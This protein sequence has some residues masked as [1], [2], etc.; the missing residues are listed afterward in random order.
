[1]KKDKYQKRRNRQR[2]FNQYDPE[3]HPAPKPP[4]AKVDEARP[5]PTH[6]PGELEDQA[7]AEAPVDPVV[8]QQEP[9]APEQVDVPLEEP[10]KEELPQEEP[11]TEV[12][13]EDPVD[14]T[15]VEEPEDV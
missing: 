8:P 11:E 3:R 14:P 13:I 10:E 5:I 6:F 12:P 4:A 9:E 2:A 15:P 7:V 1:M